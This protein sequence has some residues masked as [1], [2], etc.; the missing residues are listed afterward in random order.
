MSLRLFEARMDLDL[1][2]NYRCRYCLGHG[3]PSAPVEPYSLDYLAKAFATLGELC[4]SVYLSCAGEPLMHPRLPEVIGAANRAFALTDTSLVTNGSLLNE[5]RIGVLAASAL[6]HVF[7]SL[8]T[9]DP[10]LYSHLCGATPKSAARV[11]LQIQALARACE[12]RGAPRVGLIAIAMRSTLP[13][14]EALARFAVDSGIRVV[15]VHWLIADRPHPFIDAERV[16][17]GSALP[18]LRRVQRLLAA[19]GVAFEYPDPDLLNKAR[20][21]LARVR[22]TPAPVGYVLYQAKKLWQRR[23]LCGC[24]AAG[25][26]LTVVGDGEL[27]FCS[28]PAHSVGNVTTSSVAEL[29]ARIA[30]KIDHLRVQP[31]AEC[32]GCGFAAA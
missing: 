20:A 12:R 7:V 10:G 6:T 22:A 30:Q 16:D 29:R 8:D 31:F 23:R 11:L 24:R 32:R 13:H 14:L 26:P 1:R 19:H 9:V 21:T 18:V 5:A 27:L 4:W 17:P 25:R 3:E 2:C 28:H 15:R